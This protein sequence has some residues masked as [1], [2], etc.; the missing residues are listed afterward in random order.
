MKTQWFL[1]NR[2]DY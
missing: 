1:V 2:K